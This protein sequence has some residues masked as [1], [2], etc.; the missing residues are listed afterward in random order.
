MN[1]K[2]G[3][4][5]VELLVVIA[6]IGILIA[7]LLPAVQAA[8]EA[9][10]RMQCSNNEKQMALGIHNYANAHNDTFPLGSK[11]YMAHGLF[12]L[13]L[14]YLEAGAT[15]DRMDLESQDTQNSVLRYTPISVYACPSFPHDIVY[16]NLPQSWL[17][18]GVTTYQGVGGSLY[19]DDQ[20]VTN[21][22]DAKG[23]GNIPPNGIFDW[24][25]A[26]RISEATDGTSHTLMM[27]EYVHIE[28]NC[29]QYY[30]KAPGNL[31]MW[32]ASS[33]GPGNDT[34][35]AFKVVTDYL[36]NS[37]FGRNDG[38]PF[39]HLP[40]GSEHPGGTNFSKGDG[41]VDFVTDDIDLEVYRAIA[42]CNGGETA[43]LD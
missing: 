15:F 33:G 35:Y 43:R 30:C 42:T 3:F 31:R 22:H 13:I 36:P 16:K 12:S 32:I 5:L 27:G 28:Q 9:A 23:A 38:V 1:R 26:R 6:I 24:D 39:N 10:R 17:N 14:P 4:T 11:S 29:S 25:T 20:L 8:R 2:T 40:F 18:G 41:S 37:K 7:L 21:A 19:V 34:S